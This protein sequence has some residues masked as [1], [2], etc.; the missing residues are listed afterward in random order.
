MIGIE[1]GPTLPKGYDPFGIPHY[2]KQQKICAIYTI[3]KK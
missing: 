1:L 3:P 2:I